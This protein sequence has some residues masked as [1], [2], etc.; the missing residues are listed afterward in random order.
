MNLSKEIIDMIANP[1][2]EADT[3]KLKEFDL[4]EETIS[5]IVAIKNIFNHSTNAQN[6]LLL[7]LGLESSE[8]TFKVIKE[9]KDSLSHT[10]VESGKTQIIT[11][12]MFIATFIFGFLLLITAVYFGVLGREILATAFGGFGVFSIVTLFI[13]DAPLKL[14]DS[15][16]NYAQLTIG[17][18]AW[19]SDLLD[20]SA[21]AN[22]NQQMNL[23]LQKTCVDENQRRALYNESIENYLKIS[24]SQVTNTVKI[25]RVIDEVAEPLKKTSENKDAKD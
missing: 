3:N 14:Q 16:S 4:P 2:L 8:Q 22:I 12:R 1:L 24:D 13:K 6:K 7:E 23:E 11:T 19:F 20:K 17:L 5:K 18:L 21:M 15:R 25:L 10:L 9:L